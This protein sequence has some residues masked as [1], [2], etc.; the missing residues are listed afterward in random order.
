MGWEDG[1]SERL[2]TQV[3][4]RPCSDGCVVVG[5]GTGPAVEV[6]VREL[7]PSRLLTKSLSHLVQGPR[8]CRQPSIPVKWAPH[9]GNREPIFRSRPVVQNSG[10][11]PTSQSSSWTKGVACQHQGVRRRCQVPFTMIPHPICWIV[12]SRISVVRGRFPEHR[13]DW[14]LS[15]EVIQP[16]EPQFQQIQTPRVQ[17]QVIHCTVQRVG[18]K[19]VAKMTTLSCRLWPASHLSAH[20]SDVS[21][22]GLSRRTVGICR[23]CSGPGHQ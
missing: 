6:T 9:N 10:R 21:V 17:I 1:V 19:S 18:L 15:D 4:P 8:Q 23:R 7:C 22:W 5:A 13:E 20:Q 16:G 11:L 3:H 12:W 2:P 14:C